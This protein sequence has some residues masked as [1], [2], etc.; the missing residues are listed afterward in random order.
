MEILLVMAVLCGVIGAALG[1]SKKVGGGG[2]FILGLLLGFIGLI[3][4]AV[5]AP[6]SPLDRV[7]AK[8]ADKGWYPDPLGRFDDR[9]FDGYRWTQ[10]VGRMKDGQP[11]KLEDPI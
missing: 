3:I 4:V 5:S 1:S 2:G 10:H 11:V 8:P 6:K 7:E 9:W